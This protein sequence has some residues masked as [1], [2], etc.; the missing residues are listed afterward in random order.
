MSLLKLGGQSDRT[1]CYGDFC[2]DLACHRVLDCG[3]SRGADRSDDDD[4]FGVGGLPMRM[5]ALAVH[6]IAGGLGILAGFVALFAA[7]GATLH[8]KSGIA[9]VVAIITMGLMGAMMAAVWGRAPTSNVP[10][11]VLTA[12]LVVTALTTVR[13]PSAGSRWLD[14]GLMLVALAVCLALYTFGAEAFASPK[15]NVN[16]IPAVPFFVFG[17]VALLASV[18]DLRMIRSGGVQVIH[19]APR[20]ARHLWRMCFA[21]LIAAFSF[22]LGQAQVIPKPIRIMPLLAIPPLVVLVALL[23]WLW[24]VRTGWS[25]HGAVGVGARRAE[26]PARRGGPIALQPLARP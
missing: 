1:I 7:K 13:P 20:L 25:P 9:F 21:L 8:R 2:A 19:G 15:G 5:T 16:D 26:V 18:G 3:A 4:A 24:R 12:Y 22:F 10:V 23:Y 11:G 17:S 14:R 6:I